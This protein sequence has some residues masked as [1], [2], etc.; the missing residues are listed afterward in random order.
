ML[1]IRRPGLNPRP[2]NV[3]FVEEKVEIDRLSSSTSVS[4]TNFHSTFINHP[5]IRRCLVS[6]LTPSLHNH[7]QIKRTHI[8]SRHVGNRASIVPAKLV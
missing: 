5:I 1:A 3:G 6:I 7:L 8:L 4:P 2:R